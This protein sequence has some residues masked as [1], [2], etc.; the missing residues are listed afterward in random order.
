MRRHQ[1]SQS[2]QA[3]SGTTTAAMRAKIRTTESPEGNGAQ[4]SGAE[5][6]AFR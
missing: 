1:M 5:H 6:L 4:P 3:L 2:S